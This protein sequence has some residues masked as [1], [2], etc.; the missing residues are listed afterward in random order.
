MRRLTDAALCAQH[1]EWH[2]VHGFVPRWSRK[3]SI[4]MRRKFA[5][6]VV[7]D[8]AMHDICVL[9]EPR[10]CLLLPVFRPAIV[11]P[12]VIFIVRSPVEVAASLRLRNKP[13]LSLGIALWEFYNRQALGPSGTCRGP[14]CG[15][16]TWYRRQN[17]IFP[18]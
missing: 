8:F 13:P 17:A 16:S 14:G 4:G 11:N 2:G 1:C 15:T 5:T 18:R 12:V 9:K 10:L 6:S 7:A 3:F